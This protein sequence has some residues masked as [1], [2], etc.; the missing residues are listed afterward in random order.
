MRHSW[1]RIFFCVRF[2]TLALF[3]GMNLVQCNFFVCN[4]GWTPTHN[5]DRKI[6][7]SQFSSALS[8]FLLHRRRLLPGERRHS[9][10]SE[11]SRFR[12]EGRLQVP[13]AAGGERGES[14]AAHKIEGQ[15]L[16]T[17]R[18]PHCLTSKQRPFVTSTSACCSSLVLP[19]RYFSSS[20]AAEQ[21]ALFQ[22]TLLSGVLLQSEHKKCRSQARESVAHW[23]PCLA[24]PPC[25][26]WDLGSGWGH[27]L[28]SPTQ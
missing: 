17:A 23:E 24:L 22:I 21:G 26:F 9:P 14:G 3:N 8:P 11:V 4:L 25:S 10:L 12:R 15:P 13:A 19:P 2:E 16:L 7:F 28:F 20:Y 6:Q 18:P 5:R 27:I 1:V